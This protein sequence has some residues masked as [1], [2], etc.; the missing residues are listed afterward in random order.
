M[1]KKT[2]VKK[3][4]KK[5]KIGRDDE[6]ICFVISPIG[7]EGTKQHTEFKEVLEYIIKPAFD[8][9]DYKFSILRADDINRTGSFIKDILEN[10]YSSH[11]VIADLTGQ[12]PNVFYELGIAHTSKPSSV[13]YLLSQ[14]M[15]FIPYDLQHLRCIEY[16]PDLSNLS[17]KLKEAFS[18]EGLRQYRI[19]LR[20]GE[21]KRIPARLTGKDLCLYELE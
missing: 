21:R 10:L 16:K 4:P 19:T 3:E 18:Q 20:E 17:K 2:L 6:M 5:R 14:S 15:E 13:V 9:S 12:N 8:E 1:A 11:I 7:K